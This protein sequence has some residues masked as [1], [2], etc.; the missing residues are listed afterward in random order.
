M[1]RT[2]FRNQW[3]I[4]R[5]F[6][7]LSS[8]V[9]KSKMP[10][11]VPFPR[12]KPNCV[13]PISFSI[14]LSI[15]SKMIFNRSFI[16]WLIRLMFMNSVKLFVKL[17]EVLTSILQLGVYV[18]WV[19]ASTFVLSAIAPLHCCTSV[20]RPSCTCLF[21]PLSYVSHD[22]PDWSQVRLWI[23]PGVSHE[24]PP[25]ISWNTVKYHKKRL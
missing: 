2:L 6:S 5:H 24:S 16:T 15:R 19:R 12:L 4:R 25:L 1:G 20:S 3:N 13:S 17:K 23:V 21:Y 11:C 14:L 7:I 18:V 22:D 10:S 9:L 8:I